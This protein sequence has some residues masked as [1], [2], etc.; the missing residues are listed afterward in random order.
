L[1]KT[2]VCSKQL[3]LLSLFITKSQSEKFLTHVTKWHTWEKIS[4]E[5]WWVTLSQRGVY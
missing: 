2:T 3:F 1:D 4:S 5:S